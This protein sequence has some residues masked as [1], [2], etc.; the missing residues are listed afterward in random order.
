MS[1][2]SCVS[3]YR[4]YLEPATK[5]C[6]TTCGANM[7]G[8]GFAL[9]GRRCVPVSLV[10][11]RKTA[12]SSGAHRGSSS[13]HEVS[14]N[15]A[16]RY[17][18]SCTDFNIYYYWTG[19][20]YGGCGGGEREVDRSYCFWKAVYSEKCQVVDTNNCDYCDSNYYRASIISGYWS[21]ATCRPC[22]VCSPNQ[23]RL[24]SCERGGLDQ[25]FGCDSCGIADVAGKTGAFLPN[26]NGVPEA[27][28]RRRTTLRTTDSSANSYMG[29]SA[30]EC[31]NYYART[32]VFKNHRFL[33]AFF[34]TFFPISPLNQQL[35]E[36]TSAHPCVAR[37]ATAPTDRVTTRP[38]HSLQKFAIATTGGAESTA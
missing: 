9:T 30:C 10:R 3:S 32:F 33:H 11:E 38:K 21:P 25:N 1:Q 23:Y 34:L 8:S 35:G 29:F 36:L 16:R 20:N 22:A 5:T 24:Y 18:S 31:P 37:A 7:R 17:V 6:V 14:L 2:T 27:T 15:R 26:S 19:C 12:T 13:S 28:A 4:K